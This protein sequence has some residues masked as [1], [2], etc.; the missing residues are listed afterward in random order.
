MRLLACILFK[1][2]SMNAGRFFNQID[3]LVEVSLVV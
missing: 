3:A 2:A 1:P